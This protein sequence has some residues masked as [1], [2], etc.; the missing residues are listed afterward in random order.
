MPRLHP[1]GFCARFGFMVRLVV[2]ILVLCALIPPLRADRNPDSTPP[3]PGVDFT[4]ASPAIAM[5]WVKPGTFLM[6]STF[7][8]GDDT[9]VTLTQGYWLGRTEVTQAQWLA[10]MDDVPLPSHFQ[11]SER[12]VGKI[13]WNIVMIFCAR[14]NTQERAAGR[15]PAGYEYTLPTEAQWEYACLAGTTGIFAGDIDSLTWYDANS[16][17]QTH[18][19]GQKQPN[20][21]G[22]HDMHGNVVEWCSDWYGGYPG[23]RVNDPAGSP[24]GQFR[25]LRGGCWDCPAGSGRSAYRTWTHPSL[26]NA[27]TGFRL[28]LAPRR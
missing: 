18:P 26:G 28:A 7:G 21:W 2:A 24:T 16:G 14:L 20:D 17:G 5:I 15:L 11:G 27:A 25:V 10:V 13:T 22:F 19:V 6:S 1:V 9:E 4:A 3:L 8:A 12:P 23:G